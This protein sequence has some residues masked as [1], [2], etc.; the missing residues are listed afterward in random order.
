MT[1]KDT[2]ANFNRRH[3][4]G[5]MLAG[6]AV[7][8][9]APALLGKDRAMAQGGT[10]KGQ[11]ILGFSQEPTVFNPHL[12]H[13]E[14]D[15]GVHYA[16][17]DTLFV[18]NPDG[19][20]TPSLCAEVP[21]VE[22]GGISKDGLE[23]RV[24]LKDGITWHDGKPFT[25]EDVKFTLELMVDPNFNAWRRTG[26]TLVKDITVVSPTELTWKMEKPFA[27]FPSILAVTFILPKHAFDGVA[28]KNTAPFNNAPIGTGPFKLTSRMP[29]DRIEFE[30]NA[31]YFGD[32]P[33]LEK[34]I[35]KY[36]PD[37]TVLYTQFQT[38]D[39]DVFG[40]TWISPDN[41]DEAS[42]LPKRKVE[43]MP[44]ASVECIAFNTAHPALK[45]PAVRQAVYHALDK[46]TII[47]Q[48]YYGL[49]VATDSYVPQQSF[50]YN[51]NLP[52]H[53][54]DVEKAKDILEKAGWVAGGDGIR[55]KDGVRL[56]FTNS[57]T[58]GNHLREQL[59][60]FLQQSLAMAGIEMKISNMPSAVLFG[61]FWMMSQFESVLHGEQFLVGSD[62]D[63]SNYFMSTASAAKGGSG[64][65]F[66]Q[67]VSPEADELLVKGATTF[68]P[69]ERQAV[70]FRIQ[71]IIREELP[72]LPI[73]QK[74]RISGIKEGVDGVIANVNSRI[75][76][77]NV[78]VWKWS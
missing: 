12:M 8:A 16:L 66:W 4:L 76:N 6:G 34:F 7:S 40:M 13:I 47:E 43:V 71:E 38:G 18:A 69:E 46:A 72:F 42:K 75:D 48:L 70:Y 57:T 61:D 19:L 62:P 37:I 26:Y 39:I 23:W 44:A 51:A 56:S 35:I 2:Q 31:S 11:M 45:D 10:P 60:Q 65:N 53:E 64:L 63:V 77:W 49:P 59:Q 73:Y 41:Y 58:T 74:V 14:V 1:D 15:D 68:V 29:G 3:V 21:S 54:Y 32:G 17:F 36:V 20:Y 22:N 9:F 52:K 28:D 27:P 25:A 78:N 50:Y 5:M 55:V 33:Y 30:P 67:F 24:K